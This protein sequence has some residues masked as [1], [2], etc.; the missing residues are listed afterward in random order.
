MLTVKLQHKVTCL[1]TLIYKSL[2]KK[3]KKNLKA[4][5]AKCLLYQNVEF[6]SGT[7]TMS[8]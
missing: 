6:V 5:K 2:G 8:Y 3:S 1:L 4:D 7:K